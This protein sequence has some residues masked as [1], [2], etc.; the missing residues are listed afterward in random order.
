MKMTASLR[1]GK[2]C[3]YSR[4][5]VTSEF[6]YLLLFGRKAYSSVWIFWIFHKNLSKVRLDQFFEQISKIDTIFNKNES[7]SDFQFQVFGLRTV[8]GL[9][10]R[11]KSD[12]TR[13]PVLPSKITPKQRI[14]RHDRLFWNVS[15]WEIGNIWSR[16]LKFHQVKNKNIFDR[17]SCSMN[18]CAVAQW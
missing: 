15:H 16:P 7:F 14:F 3:N 2:F 5:M 12:L 4:R 13:N 6:D 18:L 1:K 8:S 9:L 17:S 10:K 11:Q